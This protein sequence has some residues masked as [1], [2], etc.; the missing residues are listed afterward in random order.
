[1]I[2]GKRTPD[3]SLMGTMKDS[4]G[5]PFGGRVLSRVFSE[6]YDVVEK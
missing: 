1:M 2:N 6:D 4:T 5:K 3:L